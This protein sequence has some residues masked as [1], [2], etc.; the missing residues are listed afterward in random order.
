[1]VIQP[2]GNCPEVISKIWASHVACAAE[3]LS[4][5]PENEK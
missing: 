4:I 1:M 5:I 3:V 2:N